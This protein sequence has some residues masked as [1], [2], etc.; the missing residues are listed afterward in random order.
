MDVEDIVSSAF[1]SEYDRLEGARIVV[2]TGRDGAMQYQSRL[3]VSSAEF[4]GIAERYFDLES[5]ARYLER[6]LSRASAEKRRVLEAGHRENLELLAVNYARLLRSA[7]GER[8]FV[9][10]EDL[11]K[12]TRGLRSEAPCEAYPCRPS[13]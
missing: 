4:R 2:V 11:L 3:L 10:E 12:A 7:T 8:D 5:V 6:G 9:T 1:L 13:R